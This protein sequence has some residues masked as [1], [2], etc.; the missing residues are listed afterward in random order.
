L[1]RTQ[2]TNRPVKSKN[3]TFYELH[4]SRTHEYESN[5]NPFYLENPGE[6]GTPMNDEADLGRIDGLFI[7]DLN[8]ENA[9]FDKDR[10]REAILPE[11]RNEW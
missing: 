8:A 3:K 7:A 11:K 10:H 6:G 4:Q 1:K 5:S 2:L 9:G